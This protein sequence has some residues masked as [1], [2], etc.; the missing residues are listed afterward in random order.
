MNLL[1]IS[2]SEKSCKFLREYAVTKSITIFLMAYS[3]EK[4]HDFRD[5]ILTRKVIGFS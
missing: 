4:F 2:M 1:S 3:R 5:C